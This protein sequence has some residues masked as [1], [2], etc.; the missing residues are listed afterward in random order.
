MVPITVCFIIGILLG[1][2]NTIPAT[3]VFWLLT[4]AITS[5]GA[6]YLANRFPAFRI[7]I[8]WI[9]FLAAGF[10]RLHGSNELP[11]N[12]IANLKHEDVAV[13]VTGVVTE[14]PVIIN[15]PD[16][17]RENDEEVF[18]DKLKDKIRGRFVIKCEEITPAGGNVHERFR[19]SGLVLVR[20]YDF[21]PKIKYGDRVE[22]LG[23]IS[24]PKPPSNPGGFDYRRYLHRQDIY[25]TILLTKPDNLKITSSG[26]GNFILQLVQSVRLKLS[27]KIEGNFTT[28]YQGLIK[29][30]IIGD[31]NS[32]PAYQ[33]NNFQRT[34]TIHILSVSGLHLVLVLGI[35]FWIFSILKITGNRRTIPL[36][37]ITL[38]Y[39]GL[40]G[41]NT[42]VIRSGIM[43]LVFLGADL[44]KRKSNSL[45]SLA[46]AALVILL[47]NPNELFSV[48]FQLSFICVLSMVMFYPEIMRIFPKE[49]ESLLAVIPQTWPE[50][51]WRAVKWY[52]FKGVAVSISAWIGS[53]ILVL[54][55]FNIITPVFL[56]A[57]L[58]LSPLIFLILLIGLLYLPFTLLGIPLLFPD[59]LMALC[60]AATWSVKLLSRIPG[61]YFY[62]PDIPLWVITGY[63]TVFCLW[64][65]EPYLNV[66]C[67]K[68]LFGLSVATVLV[69]IGWIITT[70]IPLSAA[71]QESCSI[72]MIDVGNGS[73][74]YLEFPDGKNMLYD[75][76]TTSPFDVGGQTIAPF[77]WAKGITKIDTVILSH[78]HLDHINGI[79][80]LLERFRVNRV[81][82]PDY[83]FEH[84]QSNN[85]KILVSLIFKMGIAIERVNRGDKI[86]LGKDVIGTV[87][88]P[89]TWDEVEKNNKAFR[90]PN[91][92][93]MILKITCKG[94]SLLLTG[95]IQTMGLIWFLES[96]QKG[97]Q[98][99]IVQIPHHGYKEP[100]IRSLIEA[101]QPRY[102]LINGT[103][104]SISDETIQIC[105][106]NNVKVISSYK[107]GAVSITLGEERINIYPYKAG[108]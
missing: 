83:W 9:L 85:G 84:S 22:I 58:I 106:E 52:I 29:A 104:N 103:E 8:I 99:D 37:V 31:Q 75:S 82:I 105:N 65:F 41:F 64:Y 57:N 40:T 18:D 20:F 60:D 33:E 36:M 3:I 34:G 1:N 61:A 68:H 10:L 35:F 101:V 78:S 38:F 80:S 66:W 4:V 67:R 21:A 2:Y 55:Y 13:I 96:E 63:Y 42:P 32:V 90:D 72:T 95:D 30:L 53:M 47:Y 102:A 6:L 73:S 54:A 74:F 51:I 59:A 24:S 19:I 76:G 39:M 87:M 16:I 45:N 86:T 5:W 107:D 100:R 81:I 12:H 62:L 88:G 48:G 15:D 23:L 50:K 28:E 43:V 11:G 56:P 49:D 91:D 89:P 93:S 46:L 69:I 17:D 79:P 97:F 70:L 14:E 98:S 92:I 71:G 108:K 44:F 77:L 25:K 27:E 94:K 26:N 7:V